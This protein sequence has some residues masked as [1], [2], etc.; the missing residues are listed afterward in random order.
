MNSI[1]LYYHFRA[2]LKEGII[3]IPD[4]DFRRLCRVTNYLAR[5]ICYR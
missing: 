5:R 2:S 4:A 1:R 3:D